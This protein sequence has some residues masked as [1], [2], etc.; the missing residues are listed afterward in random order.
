MLF[1]FFFFFFSSR[2]WHTRFD[3]DWSSD[4]CSSDLKRKIGVGVVVVKI[5]GRLLGERLF[6]VVLSHQIE[7]PKQGT[8]VDSE[9]VQSLVRTGL[10]VHRPLDRKS[11]V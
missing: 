6:G 11:V 2:R 9:Y 4:V 7:P 10:N 3:C 1:Y 8:F 5:A